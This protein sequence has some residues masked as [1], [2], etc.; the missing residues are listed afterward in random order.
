MKHLA[1]QSVVDRLEEARQRWWVFSLLCNVLLV[2]TVS[3]A[4][5]ALFVLVDAL[6][7]L[8]QRWLLVLLIVWCLISVL[9]LLVAVVRVAK[10]QRSLAAAARCVELAFP[11]LGSHL[12][13]LLQLSQP[14]DHPTDEFRQAAIA[15]AATMCRL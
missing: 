11:E 6:L 7:E 5:L 1:A 12:I 13:N 9:L 3:L 8:S 4:A 10:N 2:V 15:E 14:T